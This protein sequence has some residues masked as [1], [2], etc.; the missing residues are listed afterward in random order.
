[1]AKCQY[2][3][4]KQILNQFTRHYMHIEKKEPPKHFQHITEIPNLTL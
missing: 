2:I 3:S 4:M 1:M